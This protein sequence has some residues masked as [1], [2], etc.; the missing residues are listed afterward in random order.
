MFTRGSTP[1]V[2]TSG[3][4]VFIFSSLV[5]EHRRVLTQDKSKQDKD[6]A[7]KIIESLGF[8]L[9]L[10]GLL[11]AVAAV[12][13]IAFSIYTPA[14]WLLTGVALFIVGVILGGGGYRR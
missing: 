8:G 3:L 11:I 14:G 13:Y 9:A 1:R 10:I 7:N 6:M 4:L 2:P 5:R 12:L